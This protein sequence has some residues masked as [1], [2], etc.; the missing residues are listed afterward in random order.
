MSIRFDTATHL[1]WPPTHR[2][3]D[4]QT[5]K[6]TDNTPD[7]QI[8]QSQLTFSWQ[9]AICS[10]AHNLS[11]KPNTPSKVSSRLNWHTSMR[12]ANTPVD[13]SSF[14]AN[15]ITPARYVWFFHQMHF[16]LRSLRAATPHLDLP[17]QSKC[18]HIQTSSVNYKMMLCHGI[19]RRQNLV[20]SAFLE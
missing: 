6:K 9:A 8:K 4:K 13:M 10:A 3:T 17:N 12:N 20:K 15:H 11:Q 19:Y 14:S 7:Q 5:D 2:P 18:D 16:S 1:F